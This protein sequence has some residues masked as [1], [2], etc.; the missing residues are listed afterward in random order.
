MLAATATAQETVRPDV[1]EHRARQGFWASV[2]AGL[3]SRGLSCEFCMGSQREEGFATNFR[4]GG[5]LNRSVNLGASLT[6]W[7][8][9]HPASRGGSYGVFTSLMGVAQ[10]YPVSRAGFYFQGGGGYIVDVIDDESVNEGPGITFGIG[11]D[12]RVGRNLSITP[13]V[14]YLRTI[15]G[16]QGTSDLYQFG[17]AVTWH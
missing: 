14:N 7:I 4:I 11:Y 6:A 9:K 3:G 2:G 17:V 10:V 1:A 8:T 12:A 16:D 15:D 13:H 5:T